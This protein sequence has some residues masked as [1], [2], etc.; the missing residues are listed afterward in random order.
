M[1]ASS[2]F[3]S[4]PVGAGCSHIEVFSDCTEVALN[5]AFLVTL[6]TYLIHYSAVELVV[7]ALAK[8]GVEEVC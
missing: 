2:F 5:L 6:V 4:N 3:P 1:A 8:A 7:V